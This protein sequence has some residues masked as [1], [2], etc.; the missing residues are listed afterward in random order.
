MSEPETPEEASLI[1]EV[2]QALAGHPLELLGLVSVLIEAT[3]PDQLAGLPPHPQGDTVDLTSLLDGL[4]GVRIG[5][6]TALL[7]VLAELVDDADMRDR[8]RREVAARRDS[9]P[10]WIADLCDVEVYK[11][12]RMTHVLGDGDEVLIGA[13]LASGDEL[14]CA[15]F[16]DHNSESV[17]K[18]AFLV[19]EPIDTVVGLGIERN[20]D[21]DTSFVDMSAADARAWLDHGLRH[22]LALT[23]QSESWPACRPMLRWLVRQLPVGGSAHQSPG[24]ARGQIAELCGQFFAS[25]QGARFSRGDHGTLLEELLSGGDPLRWGVP[26]I[27]QLLGEPRYG[28]VG[29]PVEV[30][31]AAPE[32]LRCFVPFAHA[33]GGIRDEL[34]AEALD[35]IDSIAPA[36]R[37]ALLR[38][39][40]DG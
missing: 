22:G 24:W 38:D 4:I 19:P 34:T 20:T 7:A 6:T 40:A 15:A 30:A 25:A 13:R 11:A 16:V 1:D 3:R 29:V 28:S 5:E 23:E 17:V 39:I 31:L 10:G 33:R 8:C 26:R 2:R 9:L 32:L 18:D 21:P 35:A 37:E 14:T 27:E 36:Y 12:V